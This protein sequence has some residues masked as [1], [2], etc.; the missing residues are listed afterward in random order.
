MYHPY[1]QLNYYYST[2]IPNIKIYY[3]SNLIKNNQIGGNKYSYNGYD[4]IVIEDKE[5]DTENLI[6]N[7]IIF[8]GDKLKCISGIIEKDIN[9]NII[10]DYINIYNFGYSSKCDTKQPMKSLLG[11]NSMLH[12]FIQY[13][14]DNYKNNIKE[15]TLTD[16]ANYNCKDNIG[17]SY[18]IHLSLY[19]FFKYGDYYY[20]YKYGFQL[21]K[22]KQKPIYNIDKSN[23]KEYY[24]K[25]FKNKLYISNKIIERIFNDLK[26]IYLN[27]EKNINNFIQYYIDYLLTNDIITK[28]KI[29]KS[30]KNINRHKTTV[31]NNKNE[32]N[33]NFKVNHKE[34]QELLGIILILINSKSLMNFL[35]E[36]KFINCYIFDYFINNILLNYFIKYSKI[37]K[38]LFYKIVLNCEFVYYL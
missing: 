37:T 33:R 12:R 7:T 24:N 32:L 13:I 4:F 30:I 34:N 23:N 22:T 14:K 9:D 18:T 17:A 20:S 26:T 3:F 6:N 16:T 29:N 27:L 1:K 10:H 5:I 19:Y 31:K 35:K 21:D 25:Y 15:I 2:F 36:Y 28:K 38:E 8:I 11:A